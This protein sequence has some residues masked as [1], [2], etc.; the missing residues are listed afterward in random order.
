MRT[1]AAQLLNTFEWTT[2]TSVAP[3]FITFS[4]PVILVYYDRVNVLRRPKRL[5][6][7]A[8]AIELL[9]SRVICVNAAAEPRTD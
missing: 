5:A 2:Y 7:P 8:Q 9:R 1:R 3:R 4:G 6:S